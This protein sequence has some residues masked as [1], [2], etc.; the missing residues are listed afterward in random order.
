MLRLIHK[1]IPPP[2]VIPTKE[3]SPQ[4][5]QVCDFFYVKSRYDFDNGVPNEDS[6]CVG[7]TI[8]REHIG[9]NKKTIRINEWF[10]CF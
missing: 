7:M 9:L 5:I 1:R 10:F 6:S 3:E 4:D 8:L 2:F